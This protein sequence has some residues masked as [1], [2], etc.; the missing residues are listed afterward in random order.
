MD[1]RLPEVPATPE[2][3]FAYLDALGIAHSTVT[4][5]PLFT[6]ED[7]KALRGKLPGAHIKNLFLRDRKEK[8]WLLAA[9]EDRP[10]DLKKLADGLGANRLSF[11]SAERLLRHLGVQP[12]AVT[13]LA[14]I[15]ERAGAVQVVLDAGLAE[16]A[17][18]NCH[19]LVNTK[20]TALG[21][22]DLL[23][24]LSATGHEAKWL[25]L[26]PFAP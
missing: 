22:Q 2:T 9:L 15:N 13:L 21:T 19:P 18:I 26:R 11:G 23:R 20:T 24:F 16:H 25:D 17:L 12:G 6:V 10:L 5:P 8:M 1:I 14:A 4:H 3:L 7:S